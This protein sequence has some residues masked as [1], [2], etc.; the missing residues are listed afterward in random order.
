[1]STESKE[2]TLNASDYHDSEILGMA[3]RLWSRE[4]VEQGYQTQLNF[5]KFTGRPPPPA[6][7]KTLDDFAIWKLKKL[8]V[9]INAGWLREAIIS[10][11][12]EHDWYS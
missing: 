5:S 10:S 3:K 1:M 9:P 12:G 7:T 8:M 6:I 4:E 11:K 2:P